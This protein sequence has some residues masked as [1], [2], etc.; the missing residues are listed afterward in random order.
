MTT[1]KHWSDWYTGTKREWQHMSSEER[2]DASFAATGCEV[3]YPTWESPVD[4]CH[5]TCRIRRG[6][7]PKI[8]LT[9]AMLQSE[10]YHGWLQNQTKTANGRARLARLC[11]AVRKA[12]RETGQY[13]IWQ[14]GWQAIV[15]TGIDA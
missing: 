5:T 1:L 3:A 7:L 10:I 9:N 14:L 6:E 2:E 15:Y 4:C 13:D 8:A 12:A 11:I